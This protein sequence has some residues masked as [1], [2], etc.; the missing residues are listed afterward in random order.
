MNSA[1]SL[2][3]IDNLRKQMI[4][5]HERS[6]SPSVN[7]NNDKFPALHYRSNSQAVNSFDYMNR[8]ISHRFDPSVKNKTS[9]EAH[10]VKLQEILGIR[11][12]LQ[13]LPSSLE[14]LQVFCNKTEAETKERLMQDLENM[15]LKIVNQKEKFLGKVIK[16]GGLLYRTQS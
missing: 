1:N 14:E 10:E 2:R 4:Q 9:F 16:E 11:Q 6:A 7:R 13:K 12:E 5:E 15:K 3:P 8:D